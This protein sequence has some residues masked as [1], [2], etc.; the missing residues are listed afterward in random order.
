MPDPYVSTTQ[1]QS[2]STFDSELFELVPEVSESRE[3][4]VV[5]FDLYC[6]TK[7]TQIPTSRFGIQLIQTKYLGQLWPSLPK[8]AVPTSKVS[9]SRRPVLDAIST[10]L[11]A[12]S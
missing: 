2:L 3:V 10:L 8:T 7:V 5:Y 1:F 12:R 4:V 6:C 11:R 9:P